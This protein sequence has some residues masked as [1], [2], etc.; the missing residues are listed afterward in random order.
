MRRSIAAL[1]LCA[2]LF[3]TGCADVPLNFTGTSP[4]RNIRDDATIAALDATVDGFCQNGARLSVGVMRGKQ[5]RFISRGADMGEHTRLPIGRMTEVF[6]GLLA[7]NFE[8]NRWLGPDEV[9][10]EWIKTPCEVPRSGEPLKVW[11]LACNVSGL[12][13]VDE[14]GRGYFTAGMMYDQL[15]D[16]PFSA[17]PGE[18]RA[19][20][21]MGYALLGECLRQSYNMYANYINLVGNQIIGKMDLQ[22]SGFSRFDALASCDGYISTSYDLLKVA[23]YCGGMLEYDKSLSETVKLAL[24]EHWTDGEQ[25]LTLAFD[26]RDWDGHKVYFKTGET[27]DSRAFIAFMPDL[28]V[29]VSALAA[30]DC[31]IAA[32]GF[33]LLDDIT[34]PLGMSTHIS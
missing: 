34:Y 24:V 12:G 27:E 30:D 14:M 17:A 2:C 4:F 5:A 20:S 3:L 18:E 23:G 6:T 22:N 28:A 19:A 1:L 11:Q 10:S 13:G 21:D 29:G 9:V 31:D 15:A 25:T 33:A 16:A 26:V 32:L 8:Y 7:A